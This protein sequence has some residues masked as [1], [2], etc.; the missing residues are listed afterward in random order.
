MIVNILLVS[1]LVS[2]LAVIVYVV[3][4]PVP[5]GLENPWK[6]KMLTVTMKVV[7]FLGDYFPSTMAKYLDERSRPGMREKGPNVPYTNTEFDGVL[8]RV[9][10][11]QK[12][13]QI[14]TK[15]PA[16]VF[17]HGG[18]WRLGHIDMHHAILSVFARTLGVVIV[19]VEYRLA[20]KYVFPAA[21]DDC[22][23]ATVAFLRRLE[24]FNVD[25][26]RVAIMGDSAGGNLAAAVAQRLTFDPKYEG[27]PK[28]K[29]QVMIYP[30]LQAFDFQLP[31]YQQNGGYSTIVLDGYMM[32]E[33]WVIYLNNK[34]HL[35]S[36]MLQNKHTTQ[37]AKMSPK[38]KKLLSHDYIPAEFK[39][40]GYTAPPMV[41]GDQ[42][43]YEELHSGLMNPDFAPLMREDL[44]GL[45][46]AYIL[47]AQ[48]DVLRDDGIIY[49]KRLEEAGVKVTWK[50]YKKG[51]H[52]MFGHKDSPFT[53]PT[54][55]EATE[56]LM[57]FI[58]KNL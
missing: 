56:D 45:P 19:N 58:R 7:F 43:L 6:L 26:A 25:P 48:F 57:E 16:I 15:R 28:L 52:G 38:I 11:D 40:S 33:F 21:I 10:D 8:V 13:G 29:L 30:A 3:L 37:Q 42:A 50:H 46:E 17:Y 5:E 27:L 22:T 34:P 9:F 55:V 20:P 53:S 14:S 31:S 32:V 44:Q 41:E 12:T 24:E 4:L 35:T 39:Q 47:T 51:F 23:T 36:A 1:V 18:G 54:G 2:A 49:A